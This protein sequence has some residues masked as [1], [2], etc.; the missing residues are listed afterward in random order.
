MLFMNGPYGILD[1]ALGIF[2][3]VFHFWDFDDDGCVACMQN[4]Q[5]RVLAV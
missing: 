3:N 2:N 5:R 1:G 4:W